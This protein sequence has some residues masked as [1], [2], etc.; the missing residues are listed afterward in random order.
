MRRP[1]AVGLGLF[2]FASASSLGVACDE[3][4]NA[5]V[6][7]DAAPPVTA[8]DA[9]PDAS[10]PKL[11]FK[12]CP[13]GYSGACATIDV[14]LDYTKPTGRTIP[15]LIDRIVSTAHPRGQLWVLQGGPGGTAADMSG[16]GL[17]LASLVPDLDVYTLEH[18]GVGASSRLA[19]PQE[20]ELGGA[21]AGVDAGGADAGDEPVLASLRACL[22]AVKS[23]WGDDG[24]AQ[25]TT[26]NAARDLDVA[27]ERIR[28]A[29]DRQAFVYGVSYG[30]YWAHRYLQIFPAKA[31]GVVLDSIAPPVGLSIT[32]FDSQLDPQAKKLAELCK[33]SPACSAALGPDPWARLVA[34]HGEIAADHC[35]GT[36][37]N[38]N[39]RVLAGMLEGYGGGVYAFAAMARYHRCSP[40]DVTA[41]KRFITVTQSR[42]SPN[43]A[44]SAPLLGFN[45]IVSE[46]YETPA[47][48]IA[49]LDRRY[50]DHVFVS[51]SSD[52]GRVQSVW[53]SYA[54]DE[55][56]G[57]FAK[58]DVPLLMINGTIDFQT[59]I[60]LA[61][62]IGPHFTGPHQ[63]FVTVDHA[64]HGVVFQSPVRTA[65][66]PPCGA[67]IIASFLRDPLS[68]PDTSCTS[69]LAPLSFD[70]IEQ[71]ALYLFGAS[72]TW[73]PVP[74][75]PA[76]RVAAVP[77][78]AWMRQLQ[79][80]PDPTR[81]SRIFGP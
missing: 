81:K 7:T 59:P 75:A 62:T 14:P 71:D 12:A 10:G 24:L 19:C 61:S 32:D 76:D 69:R 65:G 8:S 74:Q 41:L 49:D 54:R 63:T 56:V 37:T 26:S 72:S 23:K 58:T 79:K 20:K 13:G 2:L 40:E 42:T 25:F 55:H 38:E 17:L 48:S 27:I 22:A 11:A 67:E 18:R 60:E 35:P 34:I 21:D 51:G 28:G 80:L 70:G 78:P 57:A 50:A 30:T 6:T 36:L 73:Q 4:G 16:I 47:P 64:N 33:Q 52:L 39:R 15:V 77:E 3:S 68:P 29:A 53:P 43:D 45:V 1:G 44:L 31:A 5:I 66:N 9:D 46:L